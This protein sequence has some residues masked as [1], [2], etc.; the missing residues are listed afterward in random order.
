MTPQSIPIDWTA[1]PRFGRRVSLEHTLE[2]LL[3]RRSNPLIVEFGTSYAYSPDGLGNAML[4]YAWYAGKFGARVIS[5]DVQPGGIETAGGIL[6][7]HAPAVAHIPQFIHQDCFDWAAQCH[8]PIDLLYMDAGMELVCDLGYQAFAQRF[9]DRIPS[10]YVELYNRF[11]PECFP[12]GSLMLFDDTRPDGDYWGKGHFLIPQLLREGLWR[13][14]E[15]RTVP[16]FPM[17]LLERV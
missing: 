13:Q 10:F 6:R 3:A 1:S 11:A 8:E 12:P 16:V 4:A 17:V 5:V 9:I 2:I 15:M 7:E 14:V